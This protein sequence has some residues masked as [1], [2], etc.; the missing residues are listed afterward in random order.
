MCPAHG[1][2]VVGF[3]SAEF[4]QALPQVLGRLHRLQAIEVAH[5]VKAA[6][7]RSLSRGAVIPD[8]VED[9]RVIE[10]V[11]LLEAVQDFADMVIGVFHVAG[12]NLH[13]APQYGF[14]GFGH[15]VPGRDL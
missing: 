5:L 13:L 12:I 9:E 11:E 3:G 1:V 6:V 10:D 2:V 15:G 14:E 7:D 4:V 8:D